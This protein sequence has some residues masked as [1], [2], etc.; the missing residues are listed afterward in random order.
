MYEFMVRRQMAGHNL[1]T[2]EGR[3]S[4]LRASAPVVARIRDQSLGEGYVRDLAKWLGMDFEEVR[5][6][7]KRAAFAVRNKVPESQAP[8]REETDQQGPTLTELP[9]DAITRSER[10]SLIAILQQPEAVGRSLTER[11]LGARFGNPTLAAIRDGV[12]SSLDSF[13][14]PDWIETVSNEVP[15]SLATLVSQLAVAPILVRPDRMAVYCENV[16]ADLVARDILREKAELS[17]AMQRASD[18]G[19]TDR[20]SD[21]GR[22]LAALESERRQLLRE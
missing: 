5:S 15:R 2:V 9:I 20:W 3:V 7:V 4:A 10:D 13:G 1:E 22:K 18:E 17:G 6:A 19:D 8:A 14:R 16:V 11:A 21:L 12:L